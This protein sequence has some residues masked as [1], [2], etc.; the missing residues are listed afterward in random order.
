MKYKYSKW[1]RFINIMEVIK[2]H[3]DLFMQGIKCK[4]KIRKDGWCAVFTQRKIMKA[5][6]NK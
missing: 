2:I 3:A 1:Y 6:E 4:V 5:K